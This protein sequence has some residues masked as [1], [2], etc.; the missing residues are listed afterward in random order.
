MDASAALARLGEPVATRAQLLATGA[1]PRGLTAAVRDGRLIR[2]REG[3]YAHPWTEPRL[4]HAVRIGGRL[5]CVSAA[6][7][8]GI[9]AAPHQFAHVSVDPGA[10]RLRSPR[11]RAMPLRQET[12]DGCVL[13]WLRTVDQRGGSVHTVGVLD[14][15]VQVVRCQP[16]EFAVAALDSAAYGHLVDAS[17]L[18]RVFTAVPKR[19]AAL[20]RLVDGRCMS[21]I[22]S[23][24]R[25]MLIDLGLPFEP[26]VRFP[27]I[28]TVD[29]VV[30]GCVV[31]E[32][33]GRL[34]HM[35]SLSAARDYR[36]DAAA[37]R[38]GYAV[39][40]LDY[41]QVMFEP[42][43]ALETILAAIRSHR[44]GTAG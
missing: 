37:I 11:D 5:G 36:R 7:R 21:G 9:W 15:L 25:L 2:V 41:A 44:A 39:V 33:D 1:S 18:D 29:F 34:G 26:Q 13:H 32:T 35:D 24:V 42:A 43:R 4:L 3:Y 12:S 31:V 28:G 22:E 30:A 23:L 40:R 16:A 8:L 10:S 17:D 19:L 27:G 38:L 6:E 14:A 20:R